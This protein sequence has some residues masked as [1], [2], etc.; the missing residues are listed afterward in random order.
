MSPSLPV[1]GI[2][3]WSGSGK[4]TLLEKL[5]PILTGK[6][7]KVAVI[8]HDAHGIKIDHP[9]KDSDRLFQSG[10]DV[11]LRGPE[12]GLLRIHD[13]GDGE[14]PGILGELALRYDIIL[15]EGHK[16]SPVPK[17]W[18]LNE[19]EDSPPQDVTD[20]F[21]VLPRDTNR[22]AAAASIIDEWLSKQWL[23]TPVFGCVLI[24]GKSKR[25]GIPKHLIEKDG[26]ETWLE[27]TCELLRGITQQ[28]VIVG[29]GAIPDPLREQL[30]LPD[31]PGTAGPIS[32]IL[33]AM[34]W[35]PRASWLVTACDMPALTANALNW[36]LGT[37]APGIWATMPRLPRSP[38]VEP[39]LAHYDYRSRHLLEQVIAGG[40]L[41]PADI[42]TAPQIITP[43]PPEDLIQAWQNINTQH[44]FEMLPRP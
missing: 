29:E 1:L 8:K 11:L 37:R 42:I 43:A 6:G 26:E 23:D 19:G 3:G 9:G 10:S 41:F 39:L 27:R 36:L 14:L 15:L 40:S 35:A 2:C 4:T 16:G 30:H 13:A 38:G 44:E 21:T 22:A 17:I 34:R 31:I 24:G 20:I 32:G 18:L 25:M 28:T 7:L 12:E 33:A 5:I